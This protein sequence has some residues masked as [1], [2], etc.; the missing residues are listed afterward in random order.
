MRLELEL[1]GSTDETGQPD[2]YKTWCL[3][4]PSNRR[5]LV[6]APKNLIDANESR[7]PYFSGHISL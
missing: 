4:P 3:E 6:I 7:L 5:A 1:N 2:N